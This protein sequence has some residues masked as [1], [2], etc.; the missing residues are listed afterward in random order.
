MWTD[1]FECGIFAPTGEIHCVVTFWADS[2]LAFCGTEEI[3]L[4]MLG[5]WWEANQFGEFEFL[6]QNSV[7][8]GNGCWKSGTRRK[9]LSSCEHHREHVARMQCTLESI[10]PKS[11]IVEKCIPFLD[12]NI[13]PENNKFTIGILLLI[14]LSN[15]LVNIWMKFINKFFAKYFVKFVVAKYFHDLWIFTN[16][17]SHSPSH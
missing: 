8:S 9:V 5:F 15:K 1:L 6:L 4:C 11:L 13:M 12:N 17:G 2:K 3:Y 10:S 16:N 7:C 14:L